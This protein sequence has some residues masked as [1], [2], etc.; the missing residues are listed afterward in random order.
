MGHDGGRARD[1]AG[2]CE[3]S[4]ELIDD[5]IISACTPPTGSTQSLVRQRR[6]SSYISSAEEGRPTGRRIQPFHVS[7]PH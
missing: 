6:C 3:S 1:G 4:E 2:K 7:E 5:L